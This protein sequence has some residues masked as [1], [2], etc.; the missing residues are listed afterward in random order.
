MLC[1]TVP[2]TIY[3]LQENAGHQSLYKQQL[4]YN[5]SPEF[6]LDFTWKSDI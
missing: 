4:S 1:S 5:K 3:L 2:I 6:D